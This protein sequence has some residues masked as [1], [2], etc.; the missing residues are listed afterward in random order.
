MDLITLRDIAETDS[1]VRSTI[2]LNGTN[3]ISF[4]FPTIL[5][6]ALKAKELSNLGQVTEKENDAVSAKVM[7]TIKTRGKKAYTASITSPDGKKVSAAVQS[8]LLNLV[9]GDTED[10]N[11]ELSE[12]PAISINATR[13]KKNVTIPHYLMAH[14]TRCLGNEKAA[15]RFIHETM[16]E[17]KL[18]LIENGGVNSRGKLIGDAAKTSWARKLHNHVILYLIEMSDIKETHKSPSIF[19]VKMI[20]EEKHEVK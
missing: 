4:S 6:Y 2:S 17:I 11:L 8:S 19:D 14:L 7:Q 20:H 18:S 15:R 13:A 5:L 16:F 1:P 12:N 3:A 9:L 10:E